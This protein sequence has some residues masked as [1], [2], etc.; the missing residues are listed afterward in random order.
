MQTPEDDDVELKIK[1]GDRNVLTLNKWLLVFYM[2]SVGIR[3]I[4]NRDRF[5]QDLDLLFYF[6]GI[7]FMC[8]TNQSLLK[9]SFEREGRYR[10][11]VRRLMKLLDRVE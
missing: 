1:K 7:S 5:V 3:F 6:I 10:G 9:G 4:L 8:W 11:M 2:V